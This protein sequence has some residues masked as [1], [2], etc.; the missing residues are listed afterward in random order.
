[1]SKE[2]WLDLQI[3]EANVRESETSTGGEERKPLEKATLENNLA[4]FTKS[5]D[6]FQEENKANAH[7]L[8]VSAYI[9]LCECQK[10]KKRYTFI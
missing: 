6:I 5:Y 4:I 7:K 9:Q 2:T 1:V 3:L 8:L 10:L